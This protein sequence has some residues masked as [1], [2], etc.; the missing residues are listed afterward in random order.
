[1]LGLKGLTRPDLRS[2][3][4]NGKFSRPG[5]E[6]GG[7]E[8]CRESLTPFWHSLRRGM[9]FASGFDNVSA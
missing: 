7:K 5:S 9:P 1:M 4:E 6:E 8:P 3:W 2:I